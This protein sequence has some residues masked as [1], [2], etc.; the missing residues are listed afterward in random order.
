MEEVGG[1]ENEGGNKFEAVRMGMR[2]E[3]W[4]G[5]SVCISVMLTGE[6]VV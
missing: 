2:Y 3:N 6:C 5:V 1:T 4:G